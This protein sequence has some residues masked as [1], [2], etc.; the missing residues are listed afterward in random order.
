MST[1][2]AKLSPSYGGASS[3]LREIGGLP[4]ESN[5][6]PEF[7]REAA[8]RMMR[9]SRQYRSGL[10]AGSAGR[11]FLSAGPRQADDE[12]FAALGEAATWKRQGDFV[13]FVGTKRCVSGSI[14]TRVEGHLRTI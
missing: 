3:K 1:D 13:S 6:G 9:D 8:T 7:N 12:L 2:D 5:N 4:E 10:R 14:P 11:S